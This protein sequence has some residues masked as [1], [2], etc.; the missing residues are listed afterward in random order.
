[1]AVADWRRR[2]FALYQ[3]VRQATDPAL[4]H[5]EWR[6]GRERLF[7]DHPQ[8]PLAE[9]P[10]DWTFHCYPYDPA[11]RFQA[12]LKPMNRAT[13][14]TDL[15]ADGIIRLRAFAMTDGLA[16]VCGQELTIYWIEGYGGGLF[17]PFGDAT[18]R[19]TT[20]GGGRYLLDTIKGADLGERGGRL[21]LDFNFAY[22]PSCAYS[23]AW[24][25]PLAPAENKL[26]VA[27]GAGER[28]GA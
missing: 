14:D 18:N 12:G 19:A 13:T 25:C 20:Y 10:G 8:S 11:W 3:G 6:R 7:R 5:E 23:A 24:T 4:A 27:I 28:L 9:T 15:G 1:M 2:V 21:I 26:G 17:L 16:G 22:F